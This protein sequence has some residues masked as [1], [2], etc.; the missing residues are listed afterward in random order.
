MAQRIAERL[1]A[2]PLQA[3]ADVAHWPQL[4]A[5]TRIADALLAE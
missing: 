1:P 2:A 3:M 5:P 4:E